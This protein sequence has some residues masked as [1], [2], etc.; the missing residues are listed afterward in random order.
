M[1]CMTRNQTEPRRVAHKSTGG[2]L[3]SIPEPVDP[4]GNAPS[5]TFNT[6]ARVEG[7]LDSARALTTNTVAVCALRS[8][9]SNRK[10]DARH[11]AGGSVRSSL[12]P[13]RQ[14]RF[15]LAPFGQPQYPFADNVVLNLVGACRNGAA[16][17]CEHP[18]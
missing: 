12:F 11:P 8:S 1:S 16:A 4:V 17:G 6:V 2:T 10:R 14:I 18:M 3:H 5:L 7:G 13:E 9:V 15:E